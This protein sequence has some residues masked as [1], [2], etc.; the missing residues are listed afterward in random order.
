NLGSGS[1]VNQ[2]TGDFI[3]GVVP[4]MPAQPLDKDYGFMSAVTIMTE[5]TISDATQ[6]QKAQIIADDLTV[7]VSHKRDNKGIAGVYGAKGNA[8]ILLT[9]DTT[10]NSTVTGANSNSF[11][12]YAKKGTVIDAENFIINS[13][14][15][16]YAGG[17]VAD[18]M[19]A[20]EMSLIRYQ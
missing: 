5:E 6:A 15:T 20:A 10:V 4:D 1:T 19:T 8:S 14:G 17:L 13:K 18:S 16:A 2:I 9:G 11:A 7:H 12:V 3:P